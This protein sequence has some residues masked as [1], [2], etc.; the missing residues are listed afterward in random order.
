MI[1]QYGLECWANLVE[2]LMKIRKL[3]KA[4]LVDSRPGIIT[5]F[6]IPSEITIGDW[7]EV[8]AI[9]KGSVKSGY[10]SL[11]I[12][13]ADGIKQW[14][15]DSNSRKILGSGESLQT[16]ILN[17]SNGLYESRWKFRPDPPLYPGWAKAMVCMFEE[18]SV[19]PL[20]YQEKFIHLY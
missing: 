12:Q 7:Y 2:N 17:F 8:S 19:V 1:G 20:D 5:D 13:D 4:P 15:T 14:F 3:M 6:R 11:M 9:Y 16:G 10:F 18:A